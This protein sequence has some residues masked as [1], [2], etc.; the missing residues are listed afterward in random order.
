MG[1]KM[2]PSYACLFMGYIEE[3]IRSSYDGPFPDLFR[4]FIDDCFGAS[5]LPRAD[6]DR[7]IKF[8]SNFHPAIKFTHD[9]SSSTLPFLDISVTITPDS[10]TLSTSV[11]YKPT[12]SHSYLLYSSHHPASCKNSI[13]FSQLLRLRRICSNHD[14]FQSQ[15]DTMISFF[16]ERGYPNTVCTSALEKAKN[17]TRNEALTPS[18][19]KATDDR[20]VLALTFH[21]HNIKV[22]NIIIDNFHLLQSDPR[23]SQIFPKPPLIAYKR[24]QNL[25]DHLV[26]ARVKSEVQVASRPGTTPCN[27][28]KCLTCQYVNPASVIVGPKSSF[29]LHSSHNCTSSDIVYA[30]TCALCDKVYIGETYR[31]LDDRF[32]EHHRAVRLSYNT[33]VG[34]HFNL[35]HHSLHHIRISALWHNSASPQRRRFMEAK[36]IEDLGTLK[37]AGL[38]IRP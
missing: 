18:P 38:N 25:R 4:R 5:S 37:P 10:D 27:R 17:T 32:K 28:P 3:Q 14:D 22:K 12:D 26:H 19:F 20:P 34:N 31:T 21:P 36:L 33:P 11:H 23:L 29:H 13:P 1:T 7:F 9:T 24:D 15:A 6:T 30:I 2:G 16:K 8:V 35:P